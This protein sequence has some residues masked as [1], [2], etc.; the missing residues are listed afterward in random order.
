MM[1]IPRS[2]EVDH[3]PNP[4]QTLPLL[5]DL[6]HFPSSQFLTAGK[7]IKVDTFREKRS[8]HEAQ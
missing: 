7:T 1:R 4:Y 2:F 8:S 6:T 5:G 3:H